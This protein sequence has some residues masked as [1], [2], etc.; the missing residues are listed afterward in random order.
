MADFMKRNIITDSYEFPEGA[1]KIYGSGKFYNGF[2]IAETQ[3][4]TVVNEDGLLKFSREALGGNVSSN[5]IY[6]IIPQNNKKVICAD[7]VTPLTQLLTN[8]YINDQILISSMNWSITGIRRTSESQFDVT[9]VQ[10]GGEFRLEF[11]YYQAL[12]EMMW[13]V[14]ALW[15][16]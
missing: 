1:L 11:I 14:R 3:R 6:G 4:L 12:P 8:V 5:I 2:S 13:T 7:V 15:I 10:A 16:E 9:Q